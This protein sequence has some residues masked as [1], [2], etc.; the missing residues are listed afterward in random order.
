MLAP[1]CTNPAYWEVQRALAAVPDEGAPVDCVSYLSSKATDWITQFNDILAYDPASRYVRPIG[2]SKNL[3]IR[4]LRRVIYAAPESG[5]D[6]ETLIAELQRLNDGEPLDPV[7]H[8]FETLAHALVTITDCFYIQGEGLLVPT[9]WHGVMERIYRQMPRQGVVQRHFLRLIYAEVPAFRND[10]DVCGLPIKDWVNNTFGH[11]FVA[12][13]SATT[14]GE[15]IYRARV[16][17]AGLPVELEPAI[18][19][20]SFERDVLGVL[21]VLAEDGVLKKPVSTVVDFEQDIVPFLPMSTPQHY[22]APSWDALLGRTKM[23]QWNTIVDSPSITQAESATGGDAARAPRK[24]DSS[25]ASGSVAVLVDGTG[26][27]V[28]TVNTLFKGNPL[29]ASLTDEDLG[30]R[31]VVVRRASDPAHGASDTIVSAWLNPEHLI[32]AKVSELLQTDGKH[33]RAVYVLCATNSA[34]TYLDELKGFVG[35]DLAIS[36]VTPKGCVSV[37]PAL[38]Q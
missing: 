36:V 4:T 9:E 12:S 31:K 21:D 32:T 33:L 11:Y 24:G 1:S 27:Q 10:G 15:I 14:P 37:T 7:T 13:E 17:G 35:D 23:L 30:P 18:G 34:A 3:F 26:L 6:V 2:R 25:I 16:W 38:P 20:C 28:D 19:W 29:L 22:G 8:G 5:I